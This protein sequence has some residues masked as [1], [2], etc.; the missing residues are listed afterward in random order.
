MIG[1]PD[2]SGQAGPASGRFAI[3][4]IY[5]RRSLPGNREQGSV[6]VAGPGRSSANERC[7]CHRGAFIVPAPLIL[8]DL[9]DHNRRWLS[10]TM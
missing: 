2:D 10:E 3:S 7:G 1:F 5:A 4:A 8:D 6:M 9:L